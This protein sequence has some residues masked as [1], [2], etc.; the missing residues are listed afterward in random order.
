ME[1][2]LQIE[3]MSSYFI[4]LIIYMLSTIKS[5]LG[6]IMYIFNGRIHSMYNFVQSTR[7]DGNIRPNMSA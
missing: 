1:K 2:N 3:I 6:V 5:K 7:L 4:Q